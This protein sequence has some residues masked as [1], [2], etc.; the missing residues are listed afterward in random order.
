MIRAQHEA[1]TEL[2]MENRHLRKERDEARKHL[3]A[4]NKGAEI[5]A[6]INNSL[7]AKLAKAKRERDE[8]MEDLEFRRGLYKVQEEYLETAKRERD[9]AREALRKS[10]A[11]RLESNR[12]YDRL[13]KKLWRYEERLTDVVRAARSL[14]A[15]LKHEV[16]EPS[17]YLSS[18]LLT[19]AVD[20][21]LDMKFR[22]EDTQT[23]AD[24]EGRNLERTN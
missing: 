17:V 11:A 7:A 4:A 2:V 22:V 10:E 9:E 5:N 13:A 14:L 15:L 3:A 24:P 20:K 1:I 12:D 19:E 18:K 6:H 23:D 21:A 8:A 16:Q